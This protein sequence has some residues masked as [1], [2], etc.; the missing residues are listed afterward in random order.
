MVEE[1]VQRRLAAI[2]AADVVGYSRLMGRDEA[3]T[4][5]RLKTLRSEFLHPKVAEN[6]GRVVKTTGDGTLI[7][8]ASAVEAVS[9]AIEVQQGMTERN[10]SLP[11]DQRIELRLGINVGDIIVEGEDIHGDGVNV[12]ARLEG[13]CQPGEVYISGSVFD[14]VIGKIEAVFDDLGEQP[15]ILPGEF[16]FDGRTALRKQATT[17]R[18]AQPHYRSDHNDQDGPD[19]Q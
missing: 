9:N 5:A 12:A 8:F 2:V 15:G 18:K 14:Q 10:A 19:F 4:L 1:R 3:G 17:D 13:L 16:L 7:E 6:G 11:E